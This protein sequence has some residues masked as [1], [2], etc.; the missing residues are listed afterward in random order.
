MKTVAI[1]QARSTSTRLPNKVMMKI[2]GV[3]MISLLLE[4]IKNSN[5]IDEIIVASTESKEDDQLINFVNGE[6]YNTYRGSE[7]NV[8]DRYYQAALEFNAENVVRLTADCPLL[9]FRLIDEIVREFKS[10][11]VD[12]LSN[13]I[14]PT[15]PDGLDIEVF[16][17]YALKKAWKNAKTAFDKEHVTPFI[18]TDK[19]LSLKN[20][21]N[22]DD[23]SNMRWTVDDMTI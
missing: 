8:L 1:I 21:S 7:S 16:S 12:Y 22:V 13:T 2:N 11:E 17:M 6:G 18:K 5:Q 19:S 23:L 9:D 3:P 14:E 15:F 10:S 4:R 20:Y